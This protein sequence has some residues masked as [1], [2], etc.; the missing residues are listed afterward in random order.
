[1]RYEG[2]CHCGRVRFD[3]EVDLSSPITCNCSYCAQRGS[4][5]AFT[6]RGNFNLQ[7]G[8][9]E[10]TSYRFNTNKIE[11]LFCRNCG[12]EAFAYGA[13]PDGTEMAAINLRCVDGIDLDALQPTM[14]DGR[15]R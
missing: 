8:E 12:M 14:F 9:A 7:S 2:S 11:H 5:L 1:M 3:V 6:P 15:S 13:M 4:I 10:L